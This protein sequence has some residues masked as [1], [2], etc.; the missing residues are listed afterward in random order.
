LEKLGNA[1]KENKIHASDRIGLVSDAFALSVAGKLSL[2]LVLSLLKNFKDESD[3]LVW[4]EISSQLSQLLSIWWEQPTEDQSHLKEFIAELYAHQ[5]EKLGFDFKSDESDKIKLLRP[6]IIGMAGKCGNSKVIDEA[7]KRFAEFVAGNED[8]LH[9]NLRGTVYSMVI[10]EGGKEE[11]DSV[12]KLYQTLTVADQKLAALG[13]LGSSRVPSVIE[14]ALELT[15]DDKVVRSQDVIYITR[16]TG[17][18]PTARRATWDFVKTNWDFFYRRYGLGGGISLLG[19]VVSTA[20]QE[21]S[22]EKDADAVEAFYKDKETSTFDRTLQQS[23]ERIRM[24]AS[25]LNANKQAVAQWLRT[26]VKRAI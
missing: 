25:W 9:P 24:N 20:T 11:Y 8:V 10:R 6:L 18:N 14:N 4:G 19:R 26:N 15:K 5:A 3:Y 12:L 21:F 22:S 1:V 2:T 17:A 16:A 7:R 23:L 13:A